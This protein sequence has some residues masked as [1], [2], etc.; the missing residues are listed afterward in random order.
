MK[1]S[2][3]PSIMLYTLRLLLSV[4]LLIKLLK[5]LY[6]VLIFRKFFSNT[7][8]YELDRI[9]TGVNALALPLH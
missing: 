7:Y 4:F 8:A 3:V 1:T 5:N 6:L 2:I 9:E